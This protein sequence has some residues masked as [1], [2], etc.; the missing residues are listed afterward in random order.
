MAAGIEQTIIRHSVED[1]IRIPENEPVRPDL[2]GQL[3]AVQ[4]MNRVSIA[5]LSIERALKF[6][7]VRAGGPLT[8][9]HHLGGRLR[10]LTQH[11]QESADFL[12]HAF[13]AAVRHYRLN[14]NVD[15]AG[16]LKSLDR[17]LDVAGSDSAFQDLRYWELD[18]SPDGIL[19]RRLYLAL[20]L[21]LLHAVLELLYGRQPTDTVATRVER[22]VDEAMLFAPDLAF[23]PGTAKEDSVRS[24]LDWRWGFASLSETLAAAGR[25]QFKIGDEFANSMVVRA[26]QSLTQSV[27]PAVSYFGGTL[28][29]LPRQPREVIPPVEWLSNPL[30]QREFANTPSGMTLGRG[31]DHYSARRRVGGGWRPRQPVK[32]TPNAIWRRCS[33]GSRKSPSMAIGDSS[34]SWPASGRFAD[35]T[36][37]GPAMRMFRP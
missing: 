15:K 1:V 5:H 34:G 35:G 14:P 6:M 4:V 32:P 28:D 24:Y 12:R 37:P 9:D 10:E 27:D 3:T 11:E 26:Q 25:R 21:E 2:I 8:K 23:T 19:L 30:H 13:Q 17:Y 22:A 31:L 7:I 18:Q 36:E 20:H 29:V 33:A 16:H